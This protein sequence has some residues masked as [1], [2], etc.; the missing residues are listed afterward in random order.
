MRRESFRPSSRMARAR[1][2]LD[3]VDRAVMEQ[4]GMPYNWFD[5][6]RERR[7]VKLA[8]LKRRGKGP[9]KKGSGK[10]SK[11]NRLCDGHI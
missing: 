7:A 5:E 2:H 8:L 6:K 3:E 4:L 9:P 11:S 10:R 1:V